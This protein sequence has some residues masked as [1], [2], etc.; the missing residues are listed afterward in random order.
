M[1][2][3][4]AQSARAMRGRWAPARLAALALQ[5]QEVLVCASWSGPHLSSQGCVKYGIL[6]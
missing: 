1:R 3:M 6:D 5:L 2:L 4:Q